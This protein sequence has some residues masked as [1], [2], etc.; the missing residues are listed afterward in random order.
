MYQELEVEDVTAPVSQEWLELLQTV[1]LSVFKTLN[2]HNNNP[3][4]TSNVWIHVQGCVEEM[5]IAKSEII[6]HSVFVILDSLEI[7]FQAVRGQ[8][9][10]DQLKLSNLATHHLVEGML[11]VLKMEMLQLASV[12]GIILAILTLNVNLN[13]SQI[14]SVQQTKPVS[15]NTVKTLAQEFVD[16]MRNVMW[17]TMFLTA[18]VSQDSLEMLSQIVKE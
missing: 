18:N 1:V 2:V 17:P 12:L 3:V 15:T 6:L 4:E 13:V 7:H 14:L 10:R 5:P 8:Q 9:Q 11:N 16:S